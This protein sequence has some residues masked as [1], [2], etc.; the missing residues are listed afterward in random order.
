[1]KINTEGVSPL[2]FPGGRKFLALLVA[3]LLILA[4]FAYSMVAAANAVAGV[5]S[6]DMVKAINEAHQARLAETLTAI[7][8]IVGVF[9][10]AN[11]LVATAAS[12][13]RAAAREELSPDGE[14]ED[15]RG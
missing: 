8:S 9:L 7:V 5:E 10:G 2:N 11:T 1:M 3:L 12:R 13:A 6:V 14:D 4:L 15:L